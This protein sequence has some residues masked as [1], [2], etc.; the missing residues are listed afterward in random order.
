[1]AAAAAIAAAAAVEGVCSSQTQEQHQLD[2]AGAGSQTSKQSVVAAAAA[3]DGCLHATIDL[4]INTG[5]EDYQDLLH[6]DDSEMSHEV[7][8]AVAVGEVQDNGDG[9][10]SCSYSHTAA[11]TYELHVLNGESKHECCVLYCW[12]ELF[13]LSCGTGSYSCSYSHTVAAAYE[14]HVLNG[15]SKGDGS[16]VYCFAASTVIAF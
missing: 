15:E 10:Y 11:G 6:P 7:V 2:A 14:L 9:S 5:A 3:A 12:A 1:V 4:D 13:C 8:T 16:A